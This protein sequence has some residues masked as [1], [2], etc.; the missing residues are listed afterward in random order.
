MSLLIVLTLDRIEP[1]GDED[2]RINITT[3][4]SSELSPYDVVHSLRSTADNIGRKYLQQQHVHDGEPHNYQ[5]EA[6]GS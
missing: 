5:E 2:V 4:W 3:N 6:H 1:E